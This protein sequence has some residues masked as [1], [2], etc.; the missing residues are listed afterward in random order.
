MNSFNLD[1][2]R[3]ALLVDVCEFN[4]DFSQVIFDLDHEEPDASIDELYRR[5]RYLLRTLVLE[6][7]I[8]IAE[9]HMNASSPVSR[10][11]EREQ[12]L[13]V[14][15]ALGKIDDPRV[16]QREHTFGS[17]FFQIAITKRGQQYLDALEEST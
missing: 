12:V 5:A 11:V 9:V 16:W 8:A 6:G 3:R 1:Q 7:L 14:E 10:K 13:S 17:P 15:D 2:W 4:E